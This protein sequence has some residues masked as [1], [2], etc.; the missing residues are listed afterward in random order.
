MWLSKV[1]WRTRLSKVELGEGWR[2]PMERAGKWVEEVMRK[3][4]PSLEEQ[5][6]EERM[7]KKKREEKEAVKLIWR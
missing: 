3:A 4:R 2:K 7:E 1:V 6:G 5:E